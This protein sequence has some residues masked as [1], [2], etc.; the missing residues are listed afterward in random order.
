LGGTHDKQKLALLKY[1]N[2]KRILEVGCSVG[3]IAEAFRGF[4]SI[5][6]TGIDI[7][8]AVIDYAQMSFSK[9]PNFQFVCQDLKT[10]QLAGQPFDFILFA[11]VCHHI[12]DVE[13]QNLFKAARQLLADN[14]KLIVVDILKPEPEDSWLLHRYINIDQGEYI[15]SDASLRILIQGVS[16][17][18]EAE[19]HFVGA[20]P[21][22]FPLVARFGVY[23]LS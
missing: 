2:Q 8:P 7:D 13:C 21:V 6:Y 1:Q 16:K 23:T 9:H 17:I 12:P 11:G 5:E 15:R 10:Y 14:G 20:S 22:S 19:I 4:E 3:N 18:K